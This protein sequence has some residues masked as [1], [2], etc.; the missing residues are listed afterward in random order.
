MD[1]KG[2]LP[3]KPS[4]KTTKA[5]SCVALEL[6]VNSWIAKKIF[7]QAG[8]CQAQRTGFIIIGLGNMPWLA[9]HKIV[10]ARL[11]ASGAPSKQGSCRGQKPIVVFLC[12]E[13]H[14]RHFHH[15]KVID[16]AN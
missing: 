16:H 1:G 2:S 3:A 5:R 4:H 13:R 10:K 11:L 8:T 14:L 12:G 9:L 6:L 15:K 7:S